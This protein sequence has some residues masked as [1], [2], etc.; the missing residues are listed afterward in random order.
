MRKYKKMKK[1]I[2][3][4]MVIFV[5]YVLFIFSFASLL[6]RATEGNKVDNL[7]GYTF[8]LVIS[9][10]MEPTITT[11]SISII[12][13][14][15]ISEINTGDIICFNYNQDIVHRVIDKKVNDEGVTILNTQGDANAGPDSIEITND[16]I[17]GKVVSTFN[18]IAPLISKY[19]I[20][21]GNI[22]S[23]SL[24][25]NIIIYS[26]LIGIAGYF[27]I[28]LISNI[29][30]YL[31]SIFKT[32]SFENQLKDY[33]DDINELIIYKNILDDIINNTV[34]NTAETRFEY[35]GDRISKAK[36]MKAC[37]R[38]H[39]ESI[40]FRKGIKNSIFLAR[41]FKTFDTD[42]TNITT[43]SIKEI[44]DNTKHVCNTENDNEL[45][46]ITLEEKEDDKEIKE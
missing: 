41:L 5:V 26:I 36:A 27:I 14:C 15:D 1:A 4:K 10:S 46:E 21:P 31:S 24:T 39:S 6:L 30:F 16:M 45:E 33:K 29:I 18:Q 42:E 3:T 9:G 32:R 23:M 25:R 2:N 7:F 40:E 37:K 8:R 13:K 34:E 43:P 44:I 35:I 28:Y 20:S 12:K 38:L 22:D 17:V 11:N 19:S